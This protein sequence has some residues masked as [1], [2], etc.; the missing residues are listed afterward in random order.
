LGG[1]NDLE[2]ARALY[3]AGITVYAIH[4]AEG[5]APEPIVRLTS[6]TGGDVFVPGDERALADIFAK[7]DSMQKTET[8]RTIAEQQDNFPPYAFL[9]LIFLTFALASTF[10]LR[11]TPW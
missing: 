11:Y 9:A 1:D 10:G 3:D 4:I 7:I 6:K 5:E 2:V 8:E